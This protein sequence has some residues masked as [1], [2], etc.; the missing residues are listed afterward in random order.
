MCVCDTFDREGGSDINVSIHFLWTP[1]EPKPVFPRR[2]IW[3]RRLGPCTTPTR[4][5]GARRT[6][7]PSTPHE[8]LWPD[9]CARMCVCLCVRARARIE[10]SQGSQCRQFIDLVLLVEMM[11]FGMNA[12][13]EPFLYILLLIFWFRLLGAEKIVGIILFLINNPPI[14][15]HMQLV[16]GGEIG[17]WRCGRGKPLA[18]G[19]RHRHENGVYAAENDFVLGTVSSNTRPIHATMSAGGFS[20][21]SSCVY[22]QSIRNHMARRLSPEFGA[23]VGVKVREYIH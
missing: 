22:L 16:L 2:K 6:I 5:P 4:V 8:R 9:V 11:G 10:H 18:H 3:Q 1:P 14:L 20:E 21:T 23:G 12:D 17:R 19:P 15:K 7:G 13:G